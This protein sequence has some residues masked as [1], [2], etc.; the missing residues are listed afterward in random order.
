MTGN[1]KQASVCNKMHISSKQQ[2]LVRIE[3]N[4]GDKT[5]LMHLKNIVGVVTL[6][7]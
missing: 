3:P 2:E 4:K 6:N 7:V 5:Y 1:I